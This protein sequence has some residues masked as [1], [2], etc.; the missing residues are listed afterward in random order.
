MVV[1]WWRGLKQQGVGSKL[2]GLVRCFTAGGPVGGACRS[3][4]EVLHAMFGM[5]LW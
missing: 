3:D 2:D 4:G 5:L 1:P